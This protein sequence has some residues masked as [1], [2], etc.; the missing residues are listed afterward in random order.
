MLARM[1]WFLFLLAVLLSACQP[2]PA[3][4]AGENPQATTPVGAVAAVATNASSDQPPALPNLLVCADC[5][6]ARVELRR[7]DSLTAVRAPLGT[8]LQP[9]DVLLLTEGDA[10]VFCGAESDWDASPLPLAIDEPHGVPCGIGRPPR[11]YP[12]AATVRGDAESGPSGELYA[13]RPRSGWVL[14]DRPTLVWHEIAG[15][16]SYTVTLEGDDGIIRTTVA[17]GSPLPYPADWEPLQAEGAS[18]QLVVAT[19]HATSGEN[20]KGFSLLESQEDL[21]SKIERLRQRPLEEPARTVLLAE[22]YLSQGLRSETVELL[23]ALPGGGDL[24][25][26]QSLLGDTYLKMGLVA[27]GEAAYRRMLELAQAGGFAEAQAEAL[28]GLGWAACAERNLDAVTQNWAQARDVY[29]QNG[30]AGQLDA[31]TR[32]LDSAAMECG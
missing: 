29:E 24:I 23:E 26:V 3:P 27:E 25:A 14:G 10:A 31:G 17:A 19:A 18:Y 12:D 28:T 11:P 22:L 32:L 20:T 13:L 8:E 21:Q 30:F 15:A 7:K 1:T 5:A 4:P 2:S 6:A 16:T 9:G